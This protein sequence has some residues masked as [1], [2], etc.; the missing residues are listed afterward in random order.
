M[1]K[2][3]HFLVYNN[4]IPIVL[5]VLFLGTTATFAASP[6]AREAVIDTESAITTVDN[7]YLLNTTITDNTITITIGS[8]TEDSESYYIE[9]QLSTMEPRDG[10]WQPTT[11][12]KTLMVNKES[13][14]G[15]DLGL[16]AEEE[17]AEVHAFEVRLL[18][19][20]Q[21][22]ERRAGLTPKV[23]T[24]EYSGLVGQFFDPNQEVFPQYDPV[25]PP[26]K[27]VPLTAAEKRA[28]EA[29]QKRIADEINRQTNPPEEDEP[30]PPPEPEPTPEGENPPPEEI[31]PVEEP[32]AEIPTEPS[33]EPE[34]V[35]EGVP[36]PTPTLESIG[37]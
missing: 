34:P 11:R 1:K 8:V 19:E 4:T 35:L 31:P 21:E 24:T 2:F 30:E 23:V 3:T 37:L 5:G 10:T 22:S 12:I 15:R 7:S 17:I 13:V 36:E 14:V 26:P 9:Y 6:E 25:I 16:Y 29:D 33:P 20:T 18:K 28:Y 27:S 32:P